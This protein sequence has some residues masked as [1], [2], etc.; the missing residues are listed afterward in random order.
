MAL[1]G[2]TGVCEASLTVGWELG[3]PGEKR[4][5]GWGGVKQ[6]VGWGLEI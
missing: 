2:C 3:I 1:L 5:M 6:N 4:A